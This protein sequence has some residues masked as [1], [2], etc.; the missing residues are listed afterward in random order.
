M[1]RPIPHQVGKEEGPDKGKPPATA[2]RK[3]PGLREE[4]A[5]L[6]KDPGRPA[7]RRDP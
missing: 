7:R 6:P 5:E 1:T 4:A 2:G 3:A